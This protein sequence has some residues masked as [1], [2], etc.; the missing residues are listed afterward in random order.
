MFGWLVGKGNKKDLLV[1][2]ELNKKKIKA[3]STLLIDENNAT[4]YTEE[5]KIVSIIDEYLN[6]YTSADIPII[7]N[8]KLCETKNLQMGKL[9]EDTGIFFYL[10]KRRALCNIYLINS[11]STGV[12]K[13]YLLDGDL[14]G[15]ISLLNGKLNGIYKNYANGELIEECKY[16]NGV[17]NGVCKKYFHKGDT[18]ENSVWVNGLL[19]NN[20]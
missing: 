3:Y 13:Q 20:K 6:S 19:V 17:K 1:K 7:I 18:I 16:K 12:Y 14:Q 15:E 2:I 4:Y 8:E 9:Y 11:N 10:H 5:F